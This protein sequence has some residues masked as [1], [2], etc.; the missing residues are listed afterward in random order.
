MWKG[1]MGRKKAAT[2]LLR[3]LV[4]SLLCA[5]SLGQVFNL[6]LSVKEGLPAKTIIGDLGAGLRRPSTGFFISESRDSYVFRDLEIDADTGIISTAVILDRE[7]TDKYEFVAA[8]LTGE[9]IKVYLE[10]KDVND[11]SP[12]FPSEEVDLEISELSPPGSQ[13]Q[14]V[15]AKDEDEGE[16]GTQGYRIT[17]SEMGELF[18]LE[19]RGGS[20]NHPSLNLIL[21]SKLDRETQDFYSL[22]IEAFDGGIPVRT[23]TLQVNIRVLDENDNPPIFNQTEYHASLPENAPLMSAVCQV[24]ATDLDLGDNG[25]ITYEIN[26]RQSDPNEIFSINET[27]GV[28]Y[29]NKPLDYE[30]QAFHEL[31]ISAR[32]N[33]AQPEYSSA[34][35]GVNVLNI[36]DNSPSISVLFLSETGDAVVSEAAA[37][38][39]YVA[40]ISVSDPDFKEESVTVTLQEDDGKFTLKQTDD[41]L[42]ALCVNAELDREENDLY[43][44]KVQASDFGSPP[45]SSEMV[46]LLRVSD[47]ND[48]HPVFEKDVYI[49]GVSEDAPQ[50]SSL[51]QMR[52]RDADEGV[53]S[54]VRYS[55]LKSNQDSLLSIDPE[56]GLVTTAAAL[57]RETQM[58]VWFL[59]V[60]SDGGEPALSST[61]TVTVLVE[62][63]NDNEPVFQQQ[64]Y[65][66][67]IPEH[68]D[69]GSCFL[70]VVATDADSPEFGTLLYSLSDGFDMQDK[71]PLFKIHPQT[72]ELCVSQDID[73]DSGHTVHD[74]LIKAEDPGG[75]SAQTYVHIEVEDLNNN[76]PV[77]NPDEY[78]MSISSHTQPGTEILNVIATDRDSGSFGHVTYDILPGD[79]SSLFALDKQTGMLLLT[80]TLTHL[81]A[82]S[83]KLSITAQD[84]EGLTS[85]RP[86][87]VT[88]NVLRSAQAPA[89]FQR[90]RYTFTVPEDAPSATAVGTVEAINPADSESVSY[91]ISSG[92]PQGLFSVHPKSGLISNIKHLDHES[93]PYA[94]LVL[95]SFTDTSP[96][97]STTQVNITIADINDNAPV[98]PK[99]SDTIT[100]S[101]NTLPGT[102]L[103]I[104]HAHDDDSGANG[105]VRYHLKSTRN[106]TFV[107]DH[108]LGTVTLNQ[109]LQADHQQR[110]GLEIVAK[111]EG[112]PSLISTLSLTVNVDRT[113]AEHSLAFETLVYQ[114]EI[115]EGYRKDS[116]VIQVRAHRSRGAHLSNS[117]LHYSLEAE[118]GFPPAPFRIHPKTGWLY[119]SLNLDYETESMFRFRVLATAREASLANM[120]ATATV[121]VLVLDINDNPPV[122][123]SE[124]YY[125]TVS[126]GSSPQG[127]V[128]TVKAVDKDSGKNA[129]L[130]YI[131]LTDGKFFRI[132]AKTGEIINW[133][134]LDREQHS[135][136]RL[137]V[138]VTD[139]GHPRFNATASAHIL[140]TDIN[141]NTPQFTHL[142]A[143]KEL[144]VQIWAGLPAGSLVTNMF[145][146]DLDAAENGTVTFSLATA[147]LEDAGF[148]HFEVDSES[149]D[150]RTTEIFTQNAEP[151]Y[152]L[153][154]RAKDSGASPLEDTA[155]IHVQVHGLEALY[156]RSDHQIMRCFTVKENTEPA[157][158]IGS[159]GVSY[160]GRF[161]Y[162][163]SEGD[164]SVHFGIDG[165]SGD[166]YINQPLDYESAVQY[167]LMIRA[168]DV[169]LAPG[170]NMSVLV[171]VMVEDVNDHTP[172]F[173]DKL[174]MFGLWED[175][176]VGS[177]AFA[178]HARDADGT[179]PNSAL[180]YSLSFDSQLSRSSSRFP[181]QINPHT[182]SLTVTAPLDRETNPSY[183]FTVTATDQ[184]KRK[185]ERKQT[186][187]TAQVFLLDVN[188]NRPVFVSADT[189]QV[190]ED[191]EVRSL[192]HHFV[193]I[194][195]DQGENGVVSY[196]IIGGN[197]K[198]FFTLEEETGLLFLS[199][200]LDY[201]TLRFHRLTVR[202][203]DHGLPSLS[204]TQ[205]LTVEVGD[206]NDQIPVFSQSIY[207][208]SVAENRDPGEP[209]IRVSA[210][211]KDSEE[212]AVVWYSLLPGHGYE[213]FGINPYTGLITTTS[214]LDREQQHHFTLRVQARDSSTRPLSGTATVLCSVLDDNDNPP[215]FM[216]SSFQISLPENLSPGVVHTAQA[217][218]PDH[219]ENGTIHYSILGED[220]RGRF[221]INSHTG[222]VSTTRVLD[223]EER[224]N[225]TLTI[226]AHDYGPTQLSS[227][228]QL[229]LVLLDQNDNIPSFTR[230][231]Y[232]ASIS[233]GLP[234][235]AEILR[236]SAFDPDEG[237]N[238]DL[239]Y[240]LTEDNSQG[241]FSVDAFTGVIRTTRSLDRESRA[242]YTLRAVATDGCAQGPL[243]SVASVTIQV[244]DVNDN[245]PLCEQN[246]IN[247]WVSMRTLPNQIVT[248]L[249]A[250]DG[251]QGDN[252]TIQ[253]MLSD[254]E[255]LFDINSESGE[256]SLR[257]RVRAGFSGRKLQVVVSD[258]GEPALTSTCLVFIHLKGEHEGLQFTNKV[259]NATVKENS[260]AGTWIA[261]V[262]ASDQTNSRQRVTY[263]IFSG[264]ENY[265]FSI[266]RHTGEI[267]VQKDNSLDFEVSPK[268]QLV[269]L[270]DNGLQTAHCRVSI[271]LLDVND[272]APVFEHGNYRTAVWEG[273]VHNTYIM[274]VFASDADS[275]MNGLIEYSIVSGNPNEAF[276]LDS[277]RGIL[278][279]NVMLDREIAPS[280][281]L[282]LQAADRGNPPLS[283]TTT[284]RVQ[285]VDV[286]D[287]SP[288]I[289]PMEPVVI[290]ENLPAGYMVTQVTANDVDLSSTITFSFADNSSTNVP[291]A[292]DRYTGVVTLTRALDYEEQTEYML[293]VWASDSLHQTT[294]EVKVQVLDVNDNAPVFAKVSYQVELS[295]LV[296]ADTLVLSVS[297]TD[298]DSGL[299]GKITYRLLS[300]P[301]QGFYIEPDKGSVF[302]NKPLKAI[303]NSN[304]IHLLVEAK[305][306]GDPVQSTVTS[307]DVL[308]LDTNDHTPLFH[309]DIYTLTVPEDTPTDTTLLT[310]SAEDQDWSPENTYLDYSIIRGNEEKRFCLEVKMVQ[311]E[312]QMRNVGKLVLCNPLDRETTES[313]ALTVSVSDRGTPPLN[314]TA[315]I[316]VTVTD[317]NDNAPVFSSTGYHAQVSENSHV[318]T[319]LVQVNAQ[320]PDLGTNGVLRYDIIS[321]NSKGHLKLNPQ[322]GLLVVNHSLD[323]EEDS[324]YTLTI[325]ASDGGES[326]EERKVAFTVVFITVLDVNDNTPY[327][328]FTTVNCSVLENL[329]VFTHTCSVHAVDNDLG[330]Y[331]QL[332]YSVVSS[333]FMDYGSGSPEKKQAFAIDPLTGDIHTR[334]TF[335]YERESEYCFVVEARDK[336]DKAATVRVQVTIK[337]VDEFSPVFTQKRYQFLLPENAQ[338]GETVGYVMAMDHD[339]GVDGLVEYSL[340]KSSPFFSINKTIGAIFVSGPVY[341]RRGSH[342]HED[343]IELVVSAGSPRLT[344]RTT[345]C[346]VFV[347]ISSSAEALTGVPLDAHMLSLSVSLIMFLLVLLLFV[348]LVLRYKIKE[349]AI[350]K[351]TAIAVNLN[352]GTGSFGRSIGQSA[353]SLQEIKRPIILV[354]QR[355]ISNPYNQ[356]DSSGRGSAEGETAEDQEIKWINQYPCRK[357]DKSVPGNQAIEIPDS[358]LPE[359]NI[360]CHSIDVGPEHILSVNKRLISGMASTES[361]Y[362]FKEEGGG[363]GLLPAILRVRDLEDSMKT[364]GYAPL[365]EAHASADSLSSLLCLEEELQGSYSW[366]YILDWE[367]RFQNLASVFTDIGMLPDEELQGGREDLAAEASCLM[368][369]PPL[370]TGVAQPGI[371]TVPPRKPGRIP[372]L[373]RKRSYRKYVYSPLARNTGLTPSA[374]TPTFSPSLS[375]L[376]IRTPSA[377]PVVSETGVG[378]I[379]LDS[380]PLTAS[381]LEA[382]IQV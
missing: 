311:L 93:Q 341:R 67:S 255:N 153:R 13:F 360:S 348:G 259:Y 230:K 71:H 83:V 263:N 157:T 78:T 43:E 80:S 3:T 296:S 51:I 60:A 34:F 1:A 96:V 201:E 215:E 362:H 102:V 120:T 17:E 353:I 270:A 254:E 267:R 334:Q 260:R 231:S 298:R 56:S 68:S 23:G 52:A 53:N 104:A 240:S 278:A 367:P 79:M 235:G 115:G 379:R 340:I 307:I 242:Q 81:G 140:V 37:I 118:A 292:I 69:V 317:C 125:F 131:L 183:A 154:V 191:A 124:V 335:D 286:N 351:A 374:M 237:S 8:T 92:D 207:N 33:G 313:Y 192:L 251:D 94:L 31:I 244:E 380:G 166:I 10:V 247:A 148:G 219:G 358:A 114:V 133:V 21:T 144:N 377:S 277:V 345:A 38:G 325:R 123:S 119:L 111:D 354:T 61:A 208:A 98:F 303:T 5:Q 86:A 42:Y 156:G 293:T 186:S 310:L 105:R 184:A 281:K 4:L 202:A 301:L 372:S 327:F 363:E 369:P 213:L 274:Q 190:M 121:I 218:D 168:E 58:E 211:D 145:A 375:S 320:D 36:N 245:V 336:G 100:V 88:I 366:D 349:A 214:Y 285:V 40:R 258:Q 27:S 344:S 73:R 234:L 347:N 22:A 364:N 350:K 197:K 97:Y 122:F 297:A 46:L 357:R 99:L 164:G 193:A 47:T 339:G 135:Q 162:S 18:Y 29:L 45:L 302:T 337:G 272:N 129:Q 177:L 84:G 41:Y 316:M 55:I 266:N 72:G 322:S 343:M 95:Q 57:D 182:G 198:G 381:L 155:V 261:K 173:L 236:V 256:I 150:I 101:Q 112:E 346:I 248:T 220:Y 306:E 44:L 232:H 32:D 76:A 359:D 368:Y 82:A 109:S 373:R 103:F 209:V 224:Q 25:R 26:R 273:Q 227:T 238:G 378:G 205:T 130:S 151:Y 7:N 288:T 77:F 70:Q 280:Y 275:G 19:Y 2:S 199:A 28:V 223:R 187:V 222:A 342:A 265:I 66:V 290:A 284:I 108:N 126:E 330:T 225:Y 65:N 74:I 204:S 171:S 59:V 147:D 142:P 62:D 9:M 295:E 305:D 54:E 249:L 180:R 252:G 329:P 268:M 203:V 250:S 318:G 106:G 299:N 49:I 289:P 35:V 212:N 137:K 264:N 271:N 188:D 333:C 149:G 24:H 174:V 331:G 170:V 226:Q 107:V 116:R 185:D 328:L 194:D 355:D 241:T 90:S 12:V 132:N 39:D 11:H 89:V 48:C 376:T 229:Q 196:V 139:Q 319:R 63:V 239:T 321:G 152:T 160:K 361:L 158:V 14:L 159:A 287:N 141:D 134:A 189:V 217:S 283:S 338:L 206:V 314:S 176:A 167:L 113:A 324:K 195:G 370:I 143:S 161:H 365:S 178:F 85:V 228:T 64:L 304:L 276:V 257:R 30:T 172:W 233:E 15:V 20:E 371:R 163:I 181:F 312:S 294:G 243:S 382:E 221:T 216:Q 309:Q 326:F 175:A 179:L 291:F 75:L 6:T 356:S 246:P 269:V 128:G 50:G 253:F 87:E 300:S 323:Y 91:R 117:G 308:I 332:T 127:L 315:V 262:E 352:N 210:S 165:S 282:V 110:Y 146:K 16:F 200:P 169:G 136:H 138:M 279:T